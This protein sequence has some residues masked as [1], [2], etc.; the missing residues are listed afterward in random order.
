M[1]ILI[2]EPG[3]TGHHL[4][5][6]EKIAKGYLESNH[7]ITLSTLKSTREHQ[8]IKNLET[9][10]KSRITFAD[11]PDSDYESAMASK[12]SDIGRELK[13]RNIFRKTYK[14]INSR[15]KVNYVFFPYLDYCLYS[16][17]LLGSPFGNTQW[18]GICMRPSF[19]YETYNIEAPKPKLSKIKELLFKR[20]LSISTLKNIYTIDETL[21]KYISDHS[22]KLKKRIVYIPDPAELKGNHSLQ[23]ARAQLDIPEDAK[24]ILVYGALN[25]RKGIQPLIESLCLANFH[26]NLHLLLV[27]KQ[28]EG[29]K[30]SIQAL[31]HKLT[32]KKQLHILDRF[33]SQDEEQMAFAASNIVWLGYQGHFTM[34]G[35]LVL[36]ATSGKP[37]IGTQQ[38]LIG[39]YI[40]NQKLGICVD[41]Q[42]QAAILK[43]LNQ[44]AREIEA[45]DSAYMSSY[46][47][48][49]NWEFFLRTLSFTEA[50]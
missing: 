24:V 10:Y 11:I 5:Y 14:K 32:V 3:S 43:A 40:Q 25:E 49:H 36:A 30:N 16:I 34:S 44:L 22:P 2:I 50:E 12:L 26:D 20:C 4:I 27:G 1:H 46:F 45:D 29:L 21:E 6:L 23:S 42:N 28:S 19:H 37:I 15:H 39:W 18:G 7:Y 38:G 33:V 31:A 13:M 41:T 17:G 47:G 9:T 35:V 8:L 48:N